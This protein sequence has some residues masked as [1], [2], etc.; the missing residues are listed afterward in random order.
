MTG[1][2]TAETGGEPT[3]GESG[4]S[5]EDRRLERIL[6]IAFGVLFAAVA[7]A[8]YAPIEPIVFVFPLWSLLVSA[9]MIA[10]VAVAVIAGVGYG[11]PGERS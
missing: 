7:L 8:V 11:W 5:T 3:P 2:K 1:V 6:W 4:G 10:A 9:A